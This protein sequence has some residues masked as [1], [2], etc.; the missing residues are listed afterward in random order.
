M[1][2]P[3]AEALTRVRDKLKPMGYG[4]LVFDSYRPWHVTK[5]FWDA[6][7]VQLHNFVADPSKGSRHNRG[8]AV[9]LG[10]YDLKTGKP[11]EMVAG[12]DE[13]ADRGFPDYPGGTSRQR[14]HRALLRRMMESE[15]FT[16]YEE[17]WWHFDYKDWRQYPILNK[18]FE[19]L[20]KK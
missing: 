12:F 15:D 10:L 9:D 17:E 7:P 8:C 20:E 3:A 13:F 18:T 16:V 1:Q 19:E 14:W 6:T 2:K 4:L 11:I 5:M